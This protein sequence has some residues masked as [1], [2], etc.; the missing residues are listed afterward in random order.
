MQDDYEW[1]IVTDAAARNVR[2]M[3]T[4]DARRLSAARRVRR[5]A[6]QA[7][8]ARRARDERRARRAGCSLATATAEAVIFQSEAAVS[9]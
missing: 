3:G 8:R 7:R 6:Q 5:R 4:V 1:R 9:E 2:L